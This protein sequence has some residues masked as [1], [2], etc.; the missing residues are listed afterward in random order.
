MGKSE[1]KTKPT[2]VNPATFLAKAA[3]DQ[4]LE[5]GKWL[6]KLFRELTGKG[7]KMWGPSIIGF[8]AYH[9]V[10]ESGREGDAPLIGFKTSIGPC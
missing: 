1:N 5:D 3:T 6:M 4:Q 7:A 8:G 10:Y 2:A 9:Y